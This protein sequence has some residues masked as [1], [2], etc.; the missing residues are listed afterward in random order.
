MLPATFSRLPFGSTRSP[1]FALQTKRDV[2]HPWTN[3][4]HIGG[5]LRTGVQRLKDATPAGVL[6]GSG[7]LATALDRLHLIDEYKILDRRAP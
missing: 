3:S 7:K 4:H 5:E 6:V 1:A 2:R